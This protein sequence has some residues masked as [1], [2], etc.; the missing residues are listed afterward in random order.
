[1]SANTASMTREISTR[2]RFLLAAGDLDNN[3]ARAAFAEFYEG[4]IRAWCRRWWLKPAD[5]DAVT[6]TTLNGLFEILPT[7]KYEPNQRFRGLLSTIIQNA[8]IDSNRKKPL[9]GRAS[10]DPR[11][12]GALH[13]KPAVNDSSVDDLMQ[14]LAGP[15]TRD[16]QLH[17]ACERVSVRVER[18]TWRAFLLATVDGRPAAEVAR[19]LGMKERTVIV[20]KCRVIK[21]IE[22]ELEAEA[23]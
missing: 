16:Q 7:F 9:A 17:A 20:Y 11:V 12:L 1:M 23:G 8:I 15:M 4:P 13:C 10:S 6:R 22:T 18:H 14:E 21:M 2:A 19:H 3:G 5:Q